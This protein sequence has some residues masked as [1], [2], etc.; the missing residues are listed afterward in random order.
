MMLDRLTGLQVFTRVVV[1]GSFSAAGRSL[2]LSQTMV[3]KHVAALEA[4]LGVALFQRST[5]RLSL[6]EAGRLLLEGGQKLLAD[7]EQIEQVVAAERQEPRGVLRLNAPVSFAIRHVAP[8][9]AEFRRMFPL[10]NV[11]LGVSDRPIDMIEEG[12]DLTLRI[13]SMPSS[14]LRA[15]KLAPI[16]MVVCAAPDY[17]ACAGIPTT[18]QDLQHHQCLGYALSE[19]AGASRWS[20]G[21]RGER[22]VAI[23]GPLV[24]N[25]GDVLREA[26]LAGQGIIYQPT[27]L[28][29]DELRAGRLRAISLDCQP[30]DE[31]DLHAVYVPGTV[32]PLKVRAMIDFLLGAYAPTPPWDRDLGF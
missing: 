24:A 17:L 25:N 8:I 14:S 4:R 11:E 13:Q 27:F 12:W 15:R 30:I 23:S 26:A 6:T 21:A 28:L 1:T 10:V 19:V 16:R 3:T 32:M 31:L 7:Y 2:S 29:A 5:R 9:L 20:F 18:V 22:S